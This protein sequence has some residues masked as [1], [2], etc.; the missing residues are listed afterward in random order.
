MAICVYV[1]VVV[2]CVYVYVERGAMLALGVVR[3]VLRAQLLCV[4]WLLEELYVVLVNV[5]FL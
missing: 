3:L 2:A 1:V 5:C 4:N